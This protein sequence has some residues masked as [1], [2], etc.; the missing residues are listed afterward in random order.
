VREEL[1]EREQA[2][3]GLAN[4]Q[5]IFMM[6]ET[7]SESLTHK[8]SVLDIHLSSV[9]PHQLKKKSSFYFILGH[10]LESRDNSFHCFRTTEN[11]KGS[12]NPLARECHNQRKK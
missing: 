4:F 11:I 6:K 3:P 9:N 7:F 2:F 12:T 8:A 1:I 10:L 5:S